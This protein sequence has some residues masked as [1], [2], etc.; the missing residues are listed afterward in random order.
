MNTGQA[1][2][3][4]ELI[5]RAKIDRNAFGDLYDIYYDRI[6]NYC[7]RRVGS[8]ETG[9]DLCAETF[10]KAMKYIG[11]Y[12]PSGAPFSSWLYAI[13]GNVIMDHFRGLK[14]QTTS[15][16][17]LTTR[18]GFE[19][20]SATDVEAEIQQEEERILLHRT[21]L[22]IQQAL[23]R[24]DEKFQEVLTLRFFEGKK[25]REIS[26]IINKNENT[27]KTLIKRGLAQLRKQCTLPEGYTL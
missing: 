15:L 24:L 20:R 18:I 5:R 25:T 14:K 21:F 9:A 22:E 10:F 17:T 11:S 13:A 8:V 26:E 12:K 23:T 27:V 3:E 2:P 1:I 7:I 16:D 4:P 19:E 6:L